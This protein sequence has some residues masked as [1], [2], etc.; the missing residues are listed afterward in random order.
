MTVLN[1]RKLRTPEPALH[2]FE[3]IG[4]ITKPE[5]EWMA[6]VLQGAFEVQD[7][8]DIL[9][10]MR[11]YDGIEAGAVFDLK[12]LKAQSQSVLHVRKYAVVGAPDWA[13]AMINFFAPISPVSA[14]T[15]DIEDEDD[16]W[17]WVRA[18]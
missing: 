13:E 7:T 2:A 9:I 16:A 17:A 3:I 1:I 4:K 10:V 5:V 14:R 11:G 6:A 18:S 12:S 8:L 15:F